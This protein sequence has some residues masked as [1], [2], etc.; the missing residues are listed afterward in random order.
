VQVARGLAV[1]ADLLQLGLFPFFFA[2]LLSPLDDLVDGIMA[3]VLTALLGWHIVFLP[4]FIAKLVP[5]V[6]LAPTWTIAALIA[7]RKSQTTGKS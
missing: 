5:F 1:A 6:D 4:T 3:I 2:G 7:T